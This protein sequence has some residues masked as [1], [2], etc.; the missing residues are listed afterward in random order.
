MLLIFAVILFVLSFSINGK[1][2]HEPLVNPFEND[3]DPCIIKLKYVPFISSATGYSNKNNALQKNYETI[4]KMADYNQ[5]K[6]MLDPT[7]RF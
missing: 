7:C 5:Y 3:N 2:K 6:R 1:C 4:L